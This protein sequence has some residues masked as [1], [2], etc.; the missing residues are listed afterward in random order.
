ML[1]LI[2]FSYGLTGL[3]P[4][5]CNAFLAGEVMRI[6][7]DE[8]ANNVKIAAQWEIALG[9]DSCDFVIQPDLE[10]YLGSSDV[11]AATKSQ[12]FDPLGITAVI[13][14]AQTFL[15]YGLVCKQLA[16]SGLTVVKRPIPRVGHNPQSLQS[17]TR[18]ALQLLIYGARQRLTG[19]QG[20]LIVTDQMRRIAA[21]GFEME[22]NLVHQLRNI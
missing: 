21:S 7:A 4:Y 8:G 10:H 13:P 16:A 11:I 19:H 12:L 6:R 17:H 3:E 14:V 2:A 1:G 5:R 15:H 9:L 20:K 18:S 22:R